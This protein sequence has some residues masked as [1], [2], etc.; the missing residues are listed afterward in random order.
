MKHMRI[1]F[2][3]VSIAATVGI[4]SAT[5]TEQ[6]TQEIIR[7]RISETLNNE[8]LTGAT[9][10][11]IVHDDPTV[12]INDNSLPSQ[13]TLEGQLI[14]ALVRKGWDD[15][16]CHTELYGREADRPYFWSSKNSE[17]H[18]H[19]QLSIVW[20]NAGNTLASY[21]QFTPVESV[22]QK[23]ISNFEKYVL[24]ISATKNKNFFL[25]FS[26]NSLDQRRK[27]LSN[28]YRLTYPEIKEAVN[29][30]IMKY[31]VYIDELLIDAKRLQ[32]HFR[33]VTNPTKNKPVDIL[34]ADEILTTVSH[35]KPDIRKNLVDHIIDKS[36]NIISLVSN[37]YYRANCK[38]ILKNRF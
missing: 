37:E 28:P 13:K 1:L 14:C 10:R 30:N 3:T 21:A 32:N 24:G 16:L 26:L 34:N 4:V 5:G 2:L 9:L 35:L 11:S 36:K 12:R 8:N 15:F 7:R 31:S 19:Y 25:H 6:E 29:Q 38:I 18:R 27:D 22:I 23:A 20:Y 33:T 17:I